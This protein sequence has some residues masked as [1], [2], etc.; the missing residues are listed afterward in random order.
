VSS[1]HSSVLTAA[2]LLSLIRTTHMLHLHR[3]HARMVVRYLSY[4]QQVFADVEVLF[5]VVG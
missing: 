4:V 2:V 1:E 5:S 3:Q